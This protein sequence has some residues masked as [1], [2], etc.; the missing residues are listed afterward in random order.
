MKGGAFHDRHPGE[1]RDLR[2]YRT[3][4]PHE[5]PP[6]IKSRVAGVTSLK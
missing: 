6:R 4:P 5:T 3:H 2:P 1:S